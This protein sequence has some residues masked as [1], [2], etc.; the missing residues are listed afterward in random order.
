M[1][2]KF[3]RFCANIS[4]NIAKDQYFL[5]LHNGSRN[6][7]VNRSDENWLFYFIVAKTCSYELKISISKNFEI[8]FPFHFKIHSH[9]I[10]CLSLL[11]DLYKILKSSAFTHEKIPNCI[12]NRKIVNVTPVNKKY[13]PTY[14]E[15]F[16]PEPMYEYMQ[17]YLIVYFVDLERLIS[18]NMLYSV[19]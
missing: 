19:I 10:G 2:N 15:N 17:Q 18:H 5:R 7:F 4:H 13:Q 8:K 6:M 3:H 9:H 11:K 1:S 14:K 16:Q 12:N